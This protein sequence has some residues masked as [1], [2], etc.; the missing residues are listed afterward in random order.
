MAVGRPAQRIGGIRRGRLR[1]RCLL[2]MDQLTMLSMLVGREKL[3]RHSCTG[4]QY[5]YRILPQKYFSSKIYRNTLERR[6]ETYPIL[7]TFL[8][9]ITTRRFGGVGA[10]KGRE[11]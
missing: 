10:P 11:K 1:G 8:F 7:E 5:P 9:L 3:T 6:T 2:D 4:I